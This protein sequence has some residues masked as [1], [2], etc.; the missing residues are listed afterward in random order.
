[1]GEVKVKMNQAGCTAFRNS[2]E[3]QQE[4]LRR[5]EN[6]KARADAMGSGVYKADVQ[7]GKKRAHALV[8]TTDEKSMASNAKHN[9]LL[10]SLD[11]GR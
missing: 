8:K 2:P 6:I 1:M 3:V 10:K 11:A 7:P 4:L 9:T 5:A